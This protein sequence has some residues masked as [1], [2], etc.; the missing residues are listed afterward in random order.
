MPWLSLTEQPCRFRFQCET[1]EVWTRF[2][3]FN[4]DWS[5]GLSPKSNRKV[6]R[7]LQG[8]GRSR[9]KRFHGNRPVARQDHFII[10]GTRQAMIA[11]LIDRSINLI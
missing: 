9:N 6:D 2:F 1:A 7:L 3:C 10:S 8:R 11:R 4:L 5:V